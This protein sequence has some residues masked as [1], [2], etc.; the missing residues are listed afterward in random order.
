M[1]I[2]RRNARQHI[3]GIVY[4]FEFF[5][6]FDVEKH[7]N[8]YLLTLSINQ[9]AVE[10]ESTS[11]LEDLDVLED[12]NDFEDELDFESFE[13]FE[14]EI[15]EIIEKKELSNAEKL[16]NR[17][18]FEDDNDFVGIKLKV[19]NDEAYKFI[20][21]IVSGTY[22][23]RSTIDDYISKNSKWSIDRLS[24]EVKAVLR[25]AIYELL[26]CKEIPQRVVVNEAIELA[27]TY[28]DEDTYKFVNGILGK[29]I[30]TLEA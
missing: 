23:N 26:Y 17:N 20:Y 29:V 21:N 14:E 5:E 13:D 15:E 18:P 28:C 25:V 12:D 8:T 24:K 19:I 1:N 27:K 11:D 9:K 7:L 6:D 4:Q 10:E 22:Q 2:S 30:K 3:F 16:L